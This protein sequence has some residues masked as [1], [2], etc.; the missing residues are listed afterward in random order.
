MEH[1]PEQDAKLR[2]AHVPEMPGTFTRHRELTIQTCITAHAWRTY[3]DAC[4]DRWLAIFFK[5][6]AG[7]TTPAFPAH[8]QPAILRIWLKMPIPFD[9]DTIHIPQSIRAGS[10]PGPLWFNFV[11]LWYDDI[12][13]YKTLFS[14]KLLVCL[15][16]F[17]TARFNRI[18]E[19]IMYRWC[20]TGL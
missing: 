7:K 16:D 4:R 5:S 11:S 18:S 9:I 2:I 13:S 15:P 1:R 17:V 8:A 20:F 14:I 3:R 10:T 12:D 19:E 6:V